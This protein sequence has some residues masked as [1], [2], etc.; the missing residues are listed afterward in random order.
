M[1]KRLYVG[2][3]WKYLSLLGLLITSLGLNDS[4]FANTFYA[5]KPNIV[6]TIKP[7]ALIAASLTGDDF[8][9]A[10]L[11]PPSANPHALSLNIRERQ[12]LADA[13]LVVWLGGG[14]ERFLIK[15]MAHHTKT[16]LELGSLPNLTWP[17]GRQD[18]LHIWLSIDNVKVILEAL[19]PQLIALA[20]LKAPI[21]RERL[22]QALL[23][24]DQ[25]HAQI[26]LLLE[27][28]RRHPFIVS[29]DGY[30][31]FVSTYGLAQLAAASRLPEEQLSVRKMVELKN[32]KEP[33]CLIAELNERAGAR[34]AHSLGVPLVIADPLGKAESVNTI[35]K[36]LLGLARSFVQCLTQ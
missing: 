29:H 30:S 36:L 33:S 14:F 3:M 7:L 35:D 19:A 28:Y 31:H 24:L 26:N 20:P 17:V 8:S 15:P 34:L 32:L 1:F 6:V 9:V 13:D 5:P 27:P 22:T 4:L 18:D 11:L 21:I 2:S 25:T 23:V 12:S 10:T 16:Q